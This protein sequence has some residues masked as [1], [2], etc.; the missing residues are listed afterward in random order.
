VDFEKRI[1]AIYQECRTPEEIDAAFAPCVRKWMN[2]SACAW[3]KRAGHCSSTLTRTCINACDYNWTTR[4]LN[5]SLRTAFLVADAL[6][7]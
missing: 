2:K 6:H 3:M 7:A 4:R 1:L 5:R